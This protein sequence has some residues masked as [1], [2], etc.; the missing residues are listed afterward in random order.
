[1]S[2]KGQNGCKIDIKGQEASVSFIRGSDRIQAMREDPVGTA[3]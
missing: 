2:I 1:M 3:A